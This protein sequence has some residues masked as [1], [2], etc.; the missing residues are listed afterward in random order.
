MV[1][2]F[3]VNLTFGFTGSKRNKGALQFYEKE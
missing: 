2:A 3:I 1:A